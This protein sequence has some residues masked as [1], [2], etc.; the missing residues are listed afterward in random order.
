MANNEN[1]ESRIA[2][3]GTLYCE[4]DHK[5]DAQAETKNLLDACDLPADWYLVFGNSS[6]QAPE[7]ETPY[8]ADYSHASSMPCVEGMFRSDPEGT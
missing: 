2:Y 4:N 5:H 7:F 3:Q 1:R 8:F 6:W